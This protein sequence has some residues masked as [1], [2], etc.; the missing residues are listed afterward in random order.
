MRRRCADAPRGWGKQWERAGLPRHVRM[1]ELGTQAMSR[2]KPG[3]TVAGRVVNALALYG[4][5]G[6]FLVIFCATNIWNRALGPSLRPRFAARPVCPHH[7]TP[8]ISRS[9]IGGAN[10]AACIAATLARGAM[11]RPLSR[12]PKG[13][14]GGQ[15]GI[16]FYRKMSVVFKRAG[17]ACTKRVLRGAWR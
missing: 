14:S 6:S 4:G 9:R 16:N 2:E 5:Y 17:A 10:R 11:G 12:H 13:R 7:R 15:A 3:G 1:M 8:A